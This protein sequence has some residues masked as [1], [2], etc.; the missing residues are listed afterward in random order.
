LIPLTL[1]TS[2]DCATLGVSNEDLG[3]LQSISAAISSVSD[4]DHGNL[5]FTTELSF[6]P[7][8]DT[9]VGMGEFLATESVGSWV[10]IV[11]VWGRL[12]ST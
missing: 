12:R 6:P 3:S 1:S 9:F 11:S 2:V 5:V 4:F 10:S 8:A 7:H